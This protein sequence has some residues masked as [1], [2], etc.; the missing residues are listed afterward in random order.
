MLKKCLGATIL[1]SASHAMA[2]ALSS[3]RLAEVVGIR[4]SYQGRLRS[5]IEAGQKAGRI[6]PDIAPKYL[7]LMLEGLLDRTVVWYR[8]NGE[9]SPA[10][11]AKVFCTLFVFG[12]R[13]RS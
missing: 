6:R 10:E 9:L 7:G 8:K 12:A 4:K 2:R 13:D 1:R 3:A 11:L 5:L